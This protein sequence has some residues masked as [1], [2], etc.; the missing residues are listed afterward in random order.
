MKSIV[1]LDNYCIPAELEQ[2]SADFVCYYNTKRYHESL[3]NVTPADV[4]FGR[5]QVILTQRELTK[6]QTLQ[7][8]RHDYL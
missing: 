1:K 6:Q 3:E 5:Q 2:A 7:Q 8:R 4:F